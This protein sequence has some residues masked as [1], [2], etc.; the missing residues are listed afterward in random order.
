MRLFLIDWPISMDNDVC[1][2][3]WQTVKSA[4]N[5]SL[6]NVDRCGTT[7]QSNTLGLYCC[8]SNNS[9][10]RV[11]NEGEKVGFCERGDRERMN[12]LSKTSIR[13]LTMTVTKIT[14]SF[15]IAFEQRY[16]LTFVPIRSTLPLWIITFHGWFLSCHN[17]NQRVVFSLIR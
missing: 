9:N 15:S 11:E 12:S 17:N 13:I 4:N 16:N 5:Q 1:W 2:P 8:L 7:F 14:F 6:L 3:K 10:I